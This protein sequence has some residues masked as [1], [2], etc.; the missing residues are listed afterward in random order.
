MAIFKRK[1]FFRM[2]G[3]LVFWRRPMQDET[4]AH[5]HWYHRFGNNDFLWREFWRGRRGTATNHKYLRA[6][7]GRLDAKRQQQP[8]DDWTNCYHP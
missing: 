6:G 4:L 7:S 1:L 8:E 3:A 5:F 2:P